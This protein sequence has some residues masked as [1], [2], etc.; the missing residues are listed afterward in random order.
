MVKTFRAVAM[1]FLALLSLTSYS[2]EGKDS[3]VTTISFHAKDEDIRDSLRRLFTQVDIPVRIQPQVAGRVNVSLTDQPF[4]KVLQTILKQISAT[5]LIEESRYVIVPRVIVGCGWEGT[6]EDRLERTKL[7]LDYDDSRFILR[8]NVLYMFEAESGRLVGHKSLTKSLKGV[9]PLSARSFNLASSNDRRE[10]ASI[11]A[12]AERYV[13]FVSG[14]TGYFTI[15]P[16]RSR[17]SNLESL[18]KALGYVLSEEVNLEAIAPQLIEVMPIE[19]KKA[20]HL[21]NTDRSMKVSKG[22]LKVACDGWQYSVDPASLEIVYAAGQSL[23][24]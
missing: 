9:G 16:N 21:L 2:Q 6:E 10:L 3:G 11:F 7:V 23:Q 13:T 18:A 19:I 8:G 5:Y 17:H 20:S 24:N 15:D 12:E 1:L 22:L 14:L 4:E